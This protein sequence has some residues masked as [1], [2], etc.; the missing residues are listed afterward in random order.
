MAFFSVKCHGTNKFPAAKYPIVG[1]CST[2]K[3]PLLDD[4]MQPIL[5]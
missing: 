5:V 3:A 2:Q 4:T 1:N